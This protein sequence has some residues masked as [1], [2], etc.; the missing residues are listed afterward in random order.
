[1]NSIILSR[2]SMPDFDPLASN[3]ASYRDDY[4]KTASINKLTTQPQLQDSISFM[5][6]RRSKSYRS[7]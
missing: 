7:N 6:T 3:Y 1:M 4:E 2:Q 5:S